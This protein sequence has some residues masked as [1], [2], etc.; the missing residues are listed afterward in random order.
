MAIFKFVSRNTEISEVLTAIR[1]NYIVLLR[2]RTN[3]GLTHFLKR[4]MQLLWDN[5]TVCFYIDGESQLSISEQIIGRTMMISKDDSPEQNKAAKLLKKHDKGDLVYSVVASCLLALD[6]VPLLPNIGTIANSLLTSI[7]ETLDTDRG[8]IE[9]FKTEKAVAHFCKTLTKKKNK[10]F[11]LLIDNSPKLSSNEYSFLQLLQERF[12]VRI[13]FTFGQETLSDEI[14]FISKFSN[15]RYSEPNYIY[16]LGKDFN[17]PDNNLIKELYA[18][19]GAQFFPERLP[20]Y[21]K[22]DRNIHVIMADIWGLPVDIDNVDPK[23]QFLLKILATVAISIPQSILFQVLRTENIE[24]MTLTDVYLQKICDQAAALGLI[25]IEDSNGTHEKTYKL[26]RQMAVSSVHKTSFVERQSIIASTIRAMDCQIESLNYDM[27]EFAIAHLE[28]DYSHAKQYIMIHT[29]L[30][31]KKRCASL[32]YLDKLNYFESIDELIFAVSVYYDYG[33]YDKPY[34]LLKTHR[35]YARKQDYQVALALICERLH[36][37]N[38]VEKLEDLFNT[39]KNPEKRCLIAAVLFVAYLNSDDSKKYTCFL[40]ENSKYYYASFQHLHNYFYLLRNIAYYIEDVTT[41]INNYEKCLAVFLYRDP[42]NYNRTISN[43]I[44]YLMRNDQN[45]VA[46]KYLTQI[47]KEAK[48]ILDYSDSAYS[49]LN[50]NYGIYLMRY[51]NE[52]PTKY[53]SS[54]PFSK[55]TTETPYIYAQV[56]LALYY[57]KRNTALALRTMS[58]VEDLVQ[59]T[60]V[61]RTKQ[62]YAINRALVEYANNIFPKKWLDIIR[63]K[64]LRGNEEYAQSLCQRYYQLLNEHVP[65]DQSMI[66]DFCLP[67]YI[68]YRY[69]KAEKLFTDF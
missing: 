65:F 59:C 24:S 19:Y 13:L 54:I 55:G 32:G 63:D 45:E 11:I 51:T 4:V 23:Y 14:E 50:N 68:F 48:I 69:F 27:L 12:N 36:I 7:K 44:C 37:D 64:P 47:S 61:P 22:S 20:Y 42:I 15:T 30:L 9:D 6:T 53:F 40:D 21:E 58:S 43:Y 52:D 2:C 67:G 66:N 34:R 3:S 8:H 35:D 29:R 57:L 62:F 46:K 41:A 18:C 10:S 38:Y 56:N 17:R 16:R 60:T 33:V 39:I 49:Y 25:T 31:H 5:D 26:S 28:H 1:E